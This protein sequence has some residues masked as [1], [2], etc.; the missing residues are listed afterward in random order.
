MSDVSNYVRRTQSSDRNDI[1]KILSIINPLSFPDPEDTGLKERI[2]FSPVTRRRTTTVTA[3]DPHREESDTRNRENAL[4][5]RIPPT[6]TYSYPLTHTTLGTLSF[7]ATGTKFGGRVTMGSGNITIGTHS[8]LNPTTELTLSGWIYSPIPASDGIVFQKNNQYELKLTTGL[9]LQFRVYSGSWKTALSTTITAN[10][11][12]H[13]VC[14]YKST[15]SG[16]KLYKNGTLVQSDSETGAIGTSSNDLGIGGDT[17]GT[18]RMASNSRL[19]I[20][21][22]LSSEANATWASNNYNGLIDMENVTEITT[23]PFF[24]DESPQ[25]NATPSYFIS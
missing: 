13:F 22:L 18:N 14:T 7:P 4:I 17:S 12:T 5:R 10:T 15:G 2:I 9:S 6:S 24:G 25:P 19:S 20:V 3:G 1:N 21:Q 16:Q 11:W 8:S 23:I